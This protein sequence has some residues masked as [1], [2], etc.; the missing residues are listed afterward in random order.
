MPTY[1]PSVNVSINGC[2]ELHEI[3]CLLTR[4]TIFGNKPIIIVIPDRCKLMYSN[5]KE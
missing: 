1:L 3:S 5:N 4:E 2:C